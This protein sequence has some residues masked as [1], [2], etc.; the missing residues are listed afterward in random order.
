MELKTLLI[1][2]RGEIAI[3][4]ARAA[5]E[6][7]L[8]SVAVY[9]QDDAKSLHIRR[10]EQAVALQ[11]AGPRA[12][13]DARQIISAAK[14]AGCDAVHPGYG[15][16]S[17]SAAFARACRDAGLVFVGPR[18]EI[19]ELFGDKTQARSLA[20]RLNVPVMSGTFAATTL[21]QARG[22]LRSL[23]SAGQMM[24]KASAGGGGRGMRV[25]AAED[26]LAD[27][28]A[29]CQSE[30]IAA[31]G[32][33]DV[34]V[35][36]YFPR[37]RHLEMQV[38]GDGRSVSHLWE[39]ECTLQRRHQ[40][41]VEMAPS[42]TLS[43]GLRE[44]LVQ[45]ALQIA[46][47][48]RYDNAGTFEFLVDASDEGSGRFAFIEA[49]ARLQVEHTVTEE[50]L[51]IDIV[52]AQLQIAAGRTLAELRLQQSDIPRPR[53]VAM[54]LR[55][56]ME[57]MRPDGSTKPSGGTL[58]V[59]EPP[60]G[61][62]IRVDTFGYA[63]YAT[64]PSFDSLLA[65]VIVHA[66]S[67][68][69]A[70]VVQRAY[71]ALCEFRIEG[72]A[73]NIGFLQ[74]LLRHPAVIGNAVDTG[75]IER[76]VAE[77]VGAD[78]GHPRLFVEV[79]SNGNRSALAGAR[80]NTD[81]PLA[82]LAHGKQASSAARSAAVVASGDALCAP[83]QGTIVSIDVHEGDAVR[84]G[85][86]VLV[87]ESMKMEHVITAT[88]S[89]HVRR[90]AVSVG[91]AV[92]EGA[93]LVEIDGAEVGHHAEV[94]E[95]SIDL[96]HIRR[97]LQEVQNRKQRTLDASRPAA[98]AR[99]RA[100]RQRTARENV[101][102]LC[103]ADTFVEYGPLVLAAQR[104]RRSVEELIEKS[105]A[106]GM[107]TGV[108][109]VNGDLFSDPGAR[110]VV[111]AYDYTVF[112]GTQGARNHAK[113]DRMIGVAQSGRMPLVLFAEGGGGRPGDTE[114]SGDS[115]GVP[116]FGDFGALSGWVPLVGI[117]S[118]RC[119]AGNASLLGCC[120]VVIATADS[121]IGMGGPA[122]VE[123]GGLGVFA[124]EEIGPLP[125]H[126]VNGVVDI[127][128]ADEAAAVSAAK[129][130]LSYF[131][132]RTLYYKSADQRMLRQAIPEN[133]L[134]VYD[135]RTI[136]ET[137]S[138]TGWVMELRRDFARGMSTAL[139]RIEGRAIGVIAN[140]PKF[141][142]G[143]IDSDGADKASRFM[144][145]CDAYDLPIVFLCDTPGIMV[146]PEIEKTALVRHSSRMF[147][148]GANLSVP[149]F[150]VVLRKAYGL[151]AIAMSGGSFKRSVATVAWPTAEFGG[152]GLEGAVKLAYR[153][154]L[155]QLTDPAER[156]RKYEEMV[157]A[158]YERGKALSIAT[159]FGVDDTIDPADTRKWLANLLRSIR[160]TP[161]PAGKRR[162]GIDAW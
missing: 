121:N 134:R 155:E 138:D 33:G 9:S 50:V 57:T 65:K 123:G 12:Y 137:L 154:E 15:F 96:D 20:L 46:S 76:N 144:Q 3:R 106:D 83:L 79:Q 42:P 100:T 147:V 157:A 109:C 19:L 71:R 59:F 21:A 97:D 115:G 54:Q 108:G 152:M 62:G 119:F 49:N 67:G 99:R 22:F 94:T 28:Y 44:R 161:R 84:R 34:Y 81:D 124:P 68:E 43:E 112:A 162:P 92:L 5:S 140:D 91:D 114:T 18:A 156:R 89:G 150:T 6:L 153:K 4:I 48:V 63:G 41:L 101:E 69:L 45:S 159:I 70:D 136:I 139:V 85:Q 14:A 51:G 86:Q 47:E 141:L 146:G 31:F 102:D 120:D 35:E 2:N 145:L 53:G 116:T 118:G 131:Q 98:V 151:G 125:V 11:G 1:A 135:I 110:A 58:Q 74:S 32:V 13:L 149:F 24:I 55:V 30:A 78:A 133:R 8:R 93:P 129:K 113:A 52:Q 132:G 77:L 158:M 73:T 56:N 127:G 130:Y 17:E 95:Q 66:P 107:V 75:F 117:T 103:D 64:T 88:D 72:V 105:P 25:V 148:I 16:L 122:M 143:A 142:G 87:M 36:E 23:G 80:V 27:A 126:L 104:A 39:R 60:G 7:G 37:A 26:E 111:M 40:K 10:A 38:I 61:R 128:V 82:V 90:I 160:A 29:R